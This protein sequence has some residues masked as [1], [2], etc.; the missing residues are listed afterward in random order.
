MLVLAR[1]SG[2]SITIGDDIVITVVAVDGGVVKVGIDA[3]REVKVLRREVYER[4][5]EANEAAAATDA[6]V[7]DG[8]PAA[9]GGAKPIG[10]EAVVTVRRGRPGTGS[11]RE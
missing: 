2:E 4:I 10:T 1:K 7:F 3:P 8:W 11:R 9:V 5:R 6:A